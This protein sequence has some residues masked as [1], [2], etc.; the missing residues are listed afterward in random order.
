[1][2]EGTRYTSSSLSICSNQH[3]VCAIQKKNEST[4]FAIQLTYFSG[5]P[6]QIMAMEKNFLGNIY[7]KVAISV[8][9]E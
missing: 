1:V 8:L 9:A 6:P 4:G 2:K 3:A 5:P 7:Y